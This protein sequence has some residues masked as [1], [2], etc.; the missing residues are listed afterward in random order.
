MADGDH[1]VRSD[2]DDLLRALDELKQLESEKRAADSSTP[3]FHE[4]ADRVEEQARM[5]MEIAG[6]QERGGNE[7]GPPDVAI[8]EIDAEHAT[9]S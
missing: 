9:D 5:V 6:Q 4:L 8:D 3:R 2:S 1:Q 7:A